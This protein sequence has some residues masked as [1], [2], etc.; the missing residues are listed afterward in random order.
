MR[1]ILGFLVGFLFLAGSFFLMPVAHAADVAA[2]TEAQKESVRAVMGKVPLYF[3][4]N[5]GQVDAAVSYYLE[6][7]DTTAYFTPT[8]VTFALTGPA[9]APSTASAKAVSG[10]PGH[11]RRVSLEER[12][13][14]TPWSEPEETAKQRWIV[15]LDFLGANPNV[16][17]RGE[18]PIATKVSYF[19]GPKDQWKTGLRT[20]GK[21]V[22]KNLWPG[23][24]LIYFGKGQQMEY[25]LVVHPGADPSQIRFAYRGAESVMVTQ[26]GHLKV[27]T[28][29]KVFGEE[30]PTVYQEVDGKRVEITSSYNLFPLNKGGQGVVPPNPNTLA[31]EG[32]GQ[33]EGVIYGFNLAPHDTTRPLVIDPPV[34]VYVSYIGGGWPDAGGGIAVDSFG[35][36]YVTGYTS[37]AEMDFPDIVGP[38]TTY[39]GGYDAFVAKVKPDGTGLDYAGYIGGDSDELGLGIA[40]DSFGAAYVTGIVDATEVEAS[41]PVTVGP[42][43]TYN[44]SYQDAFVAK[45]KPDGTGLDYA[46]YI[47]GSDDDRG[48]GIAVDSFGAAYVTGHT[49][50][51]EA[52]FPVTV[53]PD[54]TS[55]GSFDAFVAKVLPDGTGFEYVGYIGGS[56]YE[57]GYG[58]TVDSAG[59]AYVTGRTDS[60]EA[61]FPD[62]VGPDTTS[63]GGADAFVAKVK[64]DGT[65]LDYAGYIGGSNHDL[66]TGIAVD[67]VGAAYV[68]GYTWSTEVTFPVAVGP[69]T[70]HSGV[71]SDA[72]VAKVK[73]DG[74]GLDYAG[75]IGGSGSDVG[76][77]IA[78]D[79]LGAAYVTGYTDSTEATFPV[80][81]GPDTTHNGGLDA[82]VAKVVPNGT[83]LD[84]AGYIGGSG[85]DVGSGIAVDSVGAAYVTGTTRSTEATFPVTVGPDLTLNG[86]PTST[87]DAFVAKIE[88]TSPPDTDGD[89]IPDAE[90]ECPLLST[91]NVITGT[92]GN[93]TL[94]GT[95][96]NDLIRG[97]AGDDRVKGMGGNDCI[98]GGT[99]RDS[100]LGADG[101]DILQGGD[102][103]DVLRGGNGDDTL[104]GGTN[105][106][107][108]Y[109]G[110][111]TDT[112][113]DCETTFGI[114]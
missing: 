17:P 45:V 114:P 56:V 112:A 90:D 98:V 103:R 28:P 36:A 48:H 33:G 76:N 12:P 49:G 30:R 52:T 62:T 47:G 32:R 53:G 78:V 104:D 88:G 105:T 113:T 13:G 66:G 21:V 8:G 63:N 29:V 46:G 14:K 73:P 51:T 25:D 6:G 94:T 107:T 89:G 57:F 65:G 40:V 31:P 19:I 99:G 27:T 44:G 38:D 67:S 34:F 110:T 92:A 91:P 80:T 109:G 1:Q 24:D 69:D 87:G 68:T 9:E 5:R 4:E 71:F 97:L 85:S 16:V 70:T 100:L 72:F 82:F 108:C 101:D 50:S 96:G 26:E 93:D 75:Y 77:G 43:L 79:S 35:A 54:L 41:F 64:P 83:G 11:A 81:G 95:A 37:S 106:D 15:K 3:I 84:Y 20:F 86:D 60:T 58:I 59:A 23:I 74:T 10:A 61:T 7:E 18:A 55:N 39:N 111:G 102:Q 42:D 22:Y 2:P